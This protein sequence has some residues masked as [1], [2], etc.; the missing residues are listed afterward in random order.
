MPPRSRAPRRVPDAAPAAGNKPG[1][2]LATIRDGN[3]VH[4]L[5]IRNAP[6][7]PRKRKKKGKK[8]KRAAEASE[9]EP[10]AVPLTRAVVEIGN[11]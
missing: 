5:T 9:S 8:G 11:A 6:A 1:P 2:T 10:E 3:L 7:S 4:Q